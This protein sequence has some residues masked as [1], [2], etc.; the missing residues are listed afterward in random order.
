MKADEI[1]ESLETL[2]AVGTCISCFYFVNC[3]GSSIRTIREGADVS[4]LSQSQTQ[5]PS[6]A[7]N[8]IQC[9]LRLSLLLLHRREE[10][11]SNNAI[12]S[13]ARSCWDQIF[14]HTEMVFW[15]NF[16]GRSVRSTSQVKIGSPI[17][18]HRTSS[19]FFYSV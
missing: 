10:T 4:G 17:P 7:E 12:G 2:L 8:V 5:A 13:S 16:C 1:P 18:N 9:Q 6:L 11:S 19:V 3:F 14:V 15:I